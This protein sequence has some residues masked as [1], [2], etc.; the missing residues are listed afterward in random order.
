VVGA[1]G[2]VGVVLLLTAW[3]REGIATVVGVPGLDLEG[4]K[5]GRPALL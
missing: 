2:V 4:D 5:D 3:G 1:T